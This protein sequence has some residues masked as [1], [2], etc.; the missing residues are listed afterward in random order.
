MADPKCVALKCEVNDLF[1]KALKPVVLKQIRETVQTQVDKQ[2]GLS[3]DPNCKD[4]W[5]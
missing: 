4:G 5:V 1:D 2:K 3:F